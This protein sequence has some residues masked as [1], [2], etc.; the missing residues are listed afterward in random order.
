VVNVWGGRGSGFGVFDEDTVEVADWRT[1][2]ASR[3]RLLARGFSSTEGALGKQ[4]DEMFRALTS[5]SSRRSRDEAPEYFLPWYAKFRIARDEFTRAY[6]RQA[7]ELLNFRR[8]YE[9]DARKAGVL[10]S[11]PPPLSTLP[12][13]R[14]AWQILH[15]GVKTLRADLQSIA[16]KLEALDETEINTLWPKAQVPE[17]PDAAP[18]SLKELRQRAHQAR[19]A[20]L[21]AMETQL[22]GWL[23]PSPTPALDALS[24]EDLVAALGRSGNNVK[25]VAQELEVGA[26][27]LEAALRRL[28]PEEIYWQSM[29]RIDPKAFAGLAL[30]AQAEKILSAINARPDR[31]GF[32]WTWL[33]EGRLD[34]GGPAALPRLL[35][36]LVKHVISRLTELEV[37]L[38]GH[39]TLWR[40]LRETGIAEAWLLH[41]YIHR[42]RRGGQREIE[43]TRAIA[44]KLRPVIH[45]V[46]G[47]AE[48]NA[49]KGSAALKLL[50]IT[51]S[52]LTGLGR[53]AG[54]VG[55]D[56]SWVEAG[57]G[58]PAW[59]L[60]VA[61]AGA[62]A[63]TGTGMLAN[64]FFKERHHSVGRAHFEQQV[65]REIA[66]TLEP[67][68]IPI[69]VHQDT[70]EP[71]QRWPLVN[72]QYH[73]S[74]S[75]SLLER[76]AETLQR[77]HLAQDGRRILDLYLDLVTD[78]ARGAD[79]AEPQ[80]IY[81]L[82]DS[83]DQRHHDRRPIAS[84]RW[85]LWA[86][87]PAAIFLID[88]PLS[89]T[90]RL[91]IAV[92]T[93][94]IPLIVHGFRG[95]KQQVSTPQPESSQEPAAQDAPLA[96]RPRA[97]P[98]PSSLGSIK[99]LPDS[100]IPGPVLALRSAL[101]EA[102][103]S[104]AASP[105]PQHVRHYRVV[106]AY[107]PGIEEVL[108]SGTA[109]ILQDGSPGTTT[110]LTSPERGDF[111][112]FGTLGPSEA[113]ATHESR[114]S[115][116]LALVSDSNTV[117]LAQVA[118]NRSWLPALNAYLAELPAPALGVVV[119]DGV[120][121]D[122]GQFAWLAEALASRGIPA[123]WLAVTEAKP[124]AESIR[125]VVVASDGLYI[126]VRAQQA[127][128]ASTPFQT[129]WYAHWDT[130][131]TLVSEF[132]ALVL[133]PASQKAAPL[134]QALSHTP[135]SKIRGAISI[136]TESRF[137]KRLKEAAAGARPT[138][139]ALTGGFISGGLLLGLATVLSAAA[140]VLWLSPWVAGGSAMLAAIPLAAVLREQDDAIERYSQ[141]LPSDTARYF[142]RMVERIR[143]LADPDDAVMLSD[144]FIRNVGFSLPR[145]GRARNRGLLADAWS[146]VH[147][148]SSP[149]LGYAIKDTMLNTL[150]PAADAGALDYDWVA[151]LFR[152][153]PTQGSLVRIL[154]AAV[155][156]EPMTGGLRVT[157]DPVET[158]F[159]L[160]NEYFWIMDRL[161]HLASLPASDPVLPAIVL[162]LARFYAR[163]TV[164]VEE[165][166]S[167][168]RE[169]ARRHRD[170]V[171]WALLILRGPQTY[172][173]V[174]W[175]HRNPALWESH[176][177]S[178]MRSLAVRYLEA[179]A[180]WDRREHHTGI[181]FGSWSGRHNIARG[182]FPVERVFARF[183]RSPR[184]PRS[185]SGRP[186]WPT[187]EEIDERLRRAAKAAH[188]DLIQPASVRSTKFY[189]AREKIEAVAAWLRSV[190]AARPPS[191]LAAHIRRSLAD[192]ATIT[193]KIAEWVH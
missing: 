150:R 23:A 178:P 137:A 164:N 166:A 6:S 68:Q 48:G 60:I 81:D 59:W 103:G 66:Q 74:L 118:S 180:P 167:A 134:L 32:D 162:A 58:A 130:V 28:Q 188:Q 153:R 170:W 148:P 34:A 110:Y 172:D 151:D 191:A 42:Q 114:R 4:A 69:D 159:R 90:A 99:G 146:Q 104:E 165:G 176:Y 117:G 105:G 87:I 65:I 119:V 157:A 61:L 14:T 67:F 84:N 126:S 142:S 78:W 22:A 185:A 10:H 38:N 73:F 83:L 46:Q 75:R 91:V 35:D 171:L 7:K 30:G 113:L 93:L 57:V 71:F 116:I 189:D 129:Q 135:A 160:R 192:L 49:N 128:Q 51:A 108:A 54:S 124:G 72:G 41:S 1:D 56:A 125:D 11:W 138:A 88:A 186:S 154:E 177:A 55:A 184:A 144:A 127:R 5:K 94:G 27:R 2:A 158:V 18:M 123:L 40:Q 152:L 107:G 168:L 45:A 139:G 106:P 193:G 187:A 25:R 44:E 115:A 175:R 111:G 64:R 80:E 121:F 36:Y 85:H 112:S 39:Q 86:V 12:R 77:G 141:Q 143:E 147:V 102:R 24:Q 161:H 183:A 190:Q 181:E 52:L 120:Q 98:S 169:M 89:L 62:G 26:E 132:E 79:V 82:W 155:V 37:E 101:A 29:G 43:R 156:R 100:R 109:Q 21:R 15:S 13:A 8:D 19:I 95:R 47:Q 131:R 182:D 92:L 33:E 63:M 31:R 3:V 50:V 20:E 145:R 173:P 76:L 174:W 136:T 149:R 9:A 70:K 163:S 16:E 17:E 53:V 140:A 96:A 97:P 122:E 133:F 179:L